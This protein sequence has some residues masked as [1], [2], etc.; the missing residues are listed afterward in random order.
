MHLRMFLESRLFGHRGGST[1]VKSPKPRR[2]RRRKR[3]N[4]IMV[5]QWKLCRASYW[6]CHYWRR[7][8]RWIL[9]PWW[10]EEPHTSSQASWNGDQ[11][12][13]T[14]R[15]IHWRRCPSYAWWWRSCCQPSRRG[16]KRTSYAWKN[17]CPFSW[18]PGK[19]HRCR[20]CWSVLSCFCWIPFKQS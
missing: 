2:P 3:R 12:C 14:G 7:L 8:R 5:S 16:S 9:S 13:S 19:G 15:L 17:K 6:N 20:R 11:M 18:N 10:A 1:N 4:T